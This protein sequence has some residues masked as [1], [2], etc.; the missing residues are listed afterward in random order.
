M[1]FETTGPLTLS[2][3]SPFSTRAQLHLPID[4]LALVHL[5]LT[6]HEVG[7]ALWEAVQRQLHAVSSAM[8]WKVGMVAMASVRWSLYLYLSGWYCL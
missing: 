7:V 4:A 5:D 3:S 1:T 8:L 2:L 6:L